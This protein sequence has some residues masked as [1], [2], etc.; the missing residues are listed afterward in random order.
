M[1]EEQN[2]KW[3]AAYNG[4]VFHIQALQRQAQVQ[5]AITVFVGV[6]LFLDFVTNVI[7]ILKG[8]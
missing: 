2:K 6:A 3:T 4:L 7:L 1:T 5:S 8:H